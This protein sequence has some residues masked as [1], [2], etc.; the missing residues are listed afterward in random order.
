MRFDDVYETLELFYNE[1]EMAVKLLKIRPVF[2][3]HQKYFDE[4]LK[5][6]VNLLYILNKI[7]ET[8][9]QRTKLI[10]ITAKLV[11][12]DPRTSE[13]DSLLHLVISFNS[14]ILM[15][16]NI[17]N[18]DKVFPNYDLAQLLL[19]CG[20]D[21]NTVN[22]LKNAPLHLASTRS[23][24]N[25]RIVDLLLDNGAH[26]DQS[27]NLGSQPLKQL[28]SIK[29]SKIQPL[30]YTSLKCLAARKLNQ[31]YSSQKFQDS[32]KSTDASFLEEFVNIH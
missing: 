28:L 5:M 12:F 8:E 10:K 25:K 11:K 17:S 6:T 24:Y 30:K 22:K 29:E 16:G 9:E 4:I 27:N 14:T 21:P 32:F 2:N 20:S 26:L 18:Q 1:F 31:I 23:N 7:K 15:N 13:G 19:N 3:K